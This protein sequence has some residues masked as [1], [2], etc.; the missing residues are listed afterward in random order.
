MPWDIVCSAGPFWKK[1]VQNVCLLVA[2]LS[3]GEQ[4]HVDGNIG[5]NCDTII[6]Y[7]PTLRVDGKFVLFQLRHFIRRPS[8]KSV[9]LNVGMNHT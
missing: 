6:K 7:R 4:R 9:S 3:C 1:T 5:E 8:D 2:L